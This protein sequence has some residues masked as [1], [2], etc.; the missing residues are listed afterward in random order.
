MTDQ[1]AAMYRYRVDEMAI[2]AGD[3]P[4]VVF[5]HGTLMDRSM[6][7][8]QLDRLAPEYRV[9]AYNNRA[10][11]DNWLGPYDLTDLADDAA[12]LMDAKGIQ[13]CVL[14]GMSM[15]GFMALRFALRYPDR[16][17]GLVL[18]DSMAQAHTEEEKVE[19][20]GMLEMAEEAGQIP[21][22]IAE[23]VSDLLFGATTNQD[24]PDL[25]E[26]WE[27]RW[28]TYPPGAVTAEVESWLDRPDVTDRLDDIEVPVLVV[29]GEEDAAL[30]ID[31][32]EPM[33]DH[34]PDARM[35]RIPEAGHSSNLEQPDPVN[36]AIR[37]F[38]EDVY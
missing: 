25:V 19:Y 1:A 33:I 8:P 11:T 2:E 26:H 36:D 9:V 22:D 20:R 7:A 34:L 30:E 37:E 10:R 21:D 4:P 17:R 29:H 35:A 15:G 6:F 32:A 27:H 18:I 5:S 38:L 12:T 16:L 31:R 28:E 14:G 3:G 13:E 24:R 23:V